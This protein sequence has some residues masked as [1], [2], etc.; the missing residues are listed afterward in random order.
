MGSS[1]SRFGNFSAIT[2]FNI[3]PM[4]FICTILMP[5]SHRF[6]LLGVP[7]FLHILSTTP[8]SFLYIFF[9]S[10]FRYIL[11]S[12]L[13]FCLPLVPVHMYGFQLYFLFWLKKTFISR[14][15]GWFFFF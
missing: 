8:H 10:S 4:S 2:L 9:C 5:M 6:G 14:V 1:F 13:K 11:F 12:T 3:L 7:Q 15:S